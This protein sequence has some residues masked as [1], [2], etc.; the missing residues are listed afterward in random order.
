MN[1]PKPR[2]NLACEL[3][4]DEMARLQTACQNRKENSEDFVRRAIL[5]AVE[6]SE[7]ITNG[8]FGETRDDVDDTVYWQA[9][10]RQQQEQEERD[11]TAS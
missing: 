5:A 3:S 9:R 11:P 4:Q 10:F 1:S 2:I 6:A 8:R 7:S